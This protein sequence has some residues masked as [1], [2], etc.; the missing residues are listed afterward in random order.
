MSRIDQCFGA[1]RAEGRKALVPYISAGDPNAALT[2]E[3]M[4]GLVNAGANL[5]ELG[6]PFSDPMADGPVVQKAAERALAAGMTL[7]GVLS[8]VTQ[9]RASNDAVPVVLMGYLNPIER[10]GYAA[11]AKAASSAGVDGVLIVDLPPE[12]GASFLAA[13]SKEGLAPIFLLSPTT[14]AS[15]VQ[16]ICA[17]ARGYVYYVS[18]KG[19]TGAAHLDTDT[20]ARP[21]EEIRALTDLPVGVGFGIS[22]PQSAKAVASVADAVV[23]GSAI[24][25]RIEE[26]SGDPPRMLAEVC[27]LV[28]AMRSEMDT[29]E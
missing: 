20:I 21:V 9:F 7:E 29:I 3:L 28:S 5:I 19:V 26:H 16:R 6:V 27:E 8:I 2:L 11:F 14:S 23:V 22:D 10:M 15:R 4:H 13:L 12:E 17:D 25:R 18:L 1:L 24:V